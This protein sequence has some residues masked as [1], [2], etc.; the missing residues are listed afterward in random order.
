MQFTF[1][2]KALRPVIN[3]AYEQGTTFLALAKSHGA[4]IG[5]RNAP[6]K[7]PVFAYFRGCDP[8]KDEDYWENGQRIFGGDDFGMEILNRKWI[9]TMYKAK[10][11]KLIVQVNQD[12]FRFKVEYS[13]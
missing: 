10:K 7:P 12:D 13:N 3:V 2:D 5:T 6:G 4:Y 11:F 1:S 8:R 9:E